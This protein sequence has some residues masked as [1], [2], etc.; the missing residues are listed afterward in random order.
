MDEQGEIACED[1]EGW[2]SAQG[3]EDRENL[4]GGSNPSTYMGSNPPIVQ[5]LAIK[6]LTMLMGFLMLMG[7]MKIYSIILLRPHI[8]QVH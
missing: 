3:D 6:L 4:S 7:I 2:R 8:I 5:T 1:I